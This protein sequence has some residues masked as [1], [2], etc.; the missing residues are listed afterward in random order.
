MLPRKPQIVV[1]VPGRISCAKSDRDCTIVSKHV[2]AGDAWRWGSLS[3]CRCQLCDLFTFK[4]EE[5]RIWSV[6]SAGN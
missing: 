2:L 5:E 1:R 4:G 3:L 6:D